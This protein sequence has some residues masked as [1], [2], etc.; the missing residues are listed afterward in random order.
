MFLEINLIVLMTF[1]QYYVKQVNLVAQ[2][3]K[4][5]IAVLGD[6]NSVVVSLFSG[7][8]QICVPIFPSIRPPAH[9]MGF[10]HCCFII[11]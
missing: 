4:T 2:L 1:S 8:H 9:V 7:I 3:L 11:M 6:A 10:I 5:G